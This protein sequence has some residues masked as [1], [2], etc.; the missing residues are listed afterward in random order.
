MDFTYVI[1]RKAFK[2]HTPVGLLVDAWYFAHGRYCL[3]KE[4][5]RFFRTKELAESQLLL[6]VA[7]NPE[8]IGRLEIVLTERGAKMEEA[9]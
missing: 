6:E 1:R 4:D 2:G 5:A 3:L 8:Y 9:T 7:A